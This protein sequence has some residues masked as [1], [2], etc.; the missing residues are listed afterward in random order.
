MLYPMNLEAFESL[1][2][3]R[4]QTKYFWRLT[5]FLKKKKKEKN[6]GETG[7]IC[8]QNNKLWCG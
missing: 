2:V 3:W 5:F 4:Q 6:G 7:W 1:F 8:L